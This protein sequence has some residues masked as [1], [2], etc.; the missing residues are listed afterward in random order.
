M[1]DLTL[2]SNQ[3]IWD[4]NAVS[5]NYAALE[6]SQFAAT[7]GKA[8]HVEVAEPFSS[9]HLQTT[10]EGLAATDPN[11]SGYA[12]AM[13]QGAPEAETADLAAL[14]GNLDPATLWVTRL[15]AELS[16]Q[17]LSNDLTLGPSAVQAP[18]NRFLKPGT[19]LGSTPVC[20]ANPPCAESGG[21]GDGS[22]ASSPGG[23]A[24]SASGGFSSMLGAVSVLAA[25][26]L[27]LARRR[28]GR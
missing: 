20:V 5:S 3:I 9:G 4:W 27:V 25:L 13:G 18:V 16:H 6:K 21:G 10:L 17:A 24:M 14:F 2:Q 28:Q 22:G 8:W 15:H 7:Q 12:D 11:A 19:I 26:A 23:C 1:P